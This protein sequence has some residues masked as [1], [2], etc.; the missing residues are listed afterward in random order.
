MYTN[1]EFKSTPPKQKPVS[2]NRKNH[3]I[4]FSNSDDLLVRDL[5]RYNCGNYFISQI[6]SCEKVEFI[7]NL[8]SKILLRKVWWLQF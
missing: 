3:Q 8:Q 6:Q 1:Y 7:G 5:S 4:I 2:Q